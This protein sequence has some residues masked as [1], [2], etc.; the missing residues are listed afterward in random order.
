MIMT[1][2]TVAMVLF[3]VV[4]SIK[5]KLVKLQMPHLVDAMMMAIMLLAMA[6]LMIMLTV[7]MEARLTN[8]FKV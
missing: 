7:T 4:A 6:L 1:T 8:M 5:A 3:L 2:L